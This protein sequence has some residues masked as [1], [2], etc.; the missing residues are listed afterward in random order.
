MLTPIDAVRQ[1]LRRAC[2]SEYG[3]NR[4]T[5]ISYSTLRPILKHLVD[6]GEVLK[7]GHRFS[8]KEQSNEDASR[9]LHGGSPLRRIGEG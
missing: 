9:I 8:L 1:A 5:G 2:Y 4:T 3:L 7:D 6:D